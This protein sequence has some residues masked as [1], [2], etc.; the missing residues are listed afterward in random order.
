MNIKIPRDIHHEPLLFE[1]GR[2]NRESVDEGYKILE[3]PLKIDKL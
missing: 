2:E 1:D 3:F